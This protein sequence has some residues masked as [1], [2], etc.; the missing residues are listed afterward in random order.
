MPPKPKSGPGAE[1]STAKRKRQQEET[2][3][4]AW[5]SVEANRNI[6]TG[7][8][9][10]AQNKGGLAGNSVVV[11]KDAGWV[12]LAKFLSEACGVQLDKKQAAN[13]FSYLEAKFRK[14]KIWQNSSG[15]GIDD[16]D[17]QRGGCSCVYSSL[18][19]IIS[20]GISDIPSKLNWMCPQFEL[21]NSWFGNWQKYDPTSIIISGD[22]G[23]ESGDDAQRGDD[24]DVETIDRDQAVD[25]YTGGADAAEPDNGDG[26]G[27]SSV[28][29]SP[30]TSPSSASS[31]KKQQPFQP[32]TEVAV[33][34]NNVAASKALLAQT[35]ANKPPIVSS[36]S[37][38]SG[39]SGGSGGSKNFDV[40]YAK[41]Q[42]NKIACLRDIE[43]AKCAAAQS[44]Q[45][46]DHAF[47]SQHSK[48]VEEVKRE[49]A[50]L[51]QRAEHE[52][53]ARR[54]ALVAAGSAQER[55]V[56]QKIEF[57]KNLASLFV[58]DQSGKLA[59]AYLAKCGA[60]GADADP[61]V[62]MLGQF[63]QSYAPSNV[64]RD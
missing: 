38:S 27:A 9:G 13:K 52:F 16:T 63:M 14:A 31:A 35:V 51:Q 60:R 4:L 61:V 58:A 17:R 25:S 30:V 23:E 44:H 15:V 46:A 2:A 49:S 37:V 26:E 56:R 34:V 5:L 33:A 12:S 40:V 29:T 22:G 19:S 24:E 41:A 47:Q 8:A 54:D 62:A 43:F 57:E 32:R 10:S 6:V 36:P 48:E 50:L 1:A 21:W 7:A 64:R 59:D 45:A 20:P 28:L 3:I 53:Q 39:G 55:V 42:E 18:F 11:S